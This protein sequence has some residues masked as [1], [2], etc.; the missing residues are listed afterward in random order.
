M[1]KAAEKSSS[2][3]VHAESAKQDPMARVETTSDAWDVPQPDNPAA[4]WRESIIPEDL[5]VR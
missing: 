4:G 5:T 1:P 2:A 3:R